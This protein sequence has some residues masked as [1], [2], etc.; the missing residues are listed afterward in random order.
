MSGQ[1]PTLAKIKL[2]PIESKPTNFF[3]SLSPK[4]QQEI[5]RYLSQNRGVKL[6]YTPQMYDPDWIRKHDYYQTTDTDLDGDGIKDNVIYRRKKDG[7]KGTMVGF[8]GYKIKQSTL[9]ADMDVANQVEKY[10][11]R[12]KYRWRMAPAYEARMSEIKPNDI[13]DYNE[14]SKKKIEAI[15]AEYMGKYPYAKPIKKK[16]DA[17]IKQYF[18]QS[19]L[20]PVWDAFKSKIDPRN[21]LAVYKMFEKEEYA[22]LME[23]SI[24]PNDVPN[25]RRFFDG[26]YDKSNK[27][28]VRM[29]NQLN[30]RLNKQKYAFKEKILDCQDQL[31]VKADSTLRA[32]ASSLN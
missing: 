31:R 12:K 32:M 13:G 19:V 22:D 21:R 26:S 29:K 16:S 18:V 24:D 11:D 27:D 23:N 7:S 5:L 20:K 3:E 28:E 8:N 25:A 10:D 14:E 9:E 15:V 17:S 30:K 6:Q 4:E 1:D 2:E